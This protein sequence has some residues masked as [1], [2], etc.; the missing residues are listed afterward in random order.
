MK[1][2]DVPILLATAAYSLLF[3][4]QSAGL[5]YFLFDILLIIL[6]LV[7]DTSL[8]RRMTFIAAAAGCIVSSFFVFWY[9]TTLPF[10]AN[11]ISLVAVAGF[12]MDPESSFII[13][14]LHSFFSMSCVVIFMA[15][16]MLSGI[17]SPTPAGG[18]SRAFHRIFLAIIPVFIFFIFFLIYRQ[19]NPIFDQLAS[20]INFDWLSVGWLFFTLSGFL[21]MYGFFRQRV[22][23]SI[24]QRDHD[25]SDDLAVITAEQDTI[26][27]ITSA[28]NLVYTGVLLLILLNGLLAVVNGL[29]VYYLGIAHRIPA[30]IT[31]AQFLHNGTNAL[32][33]S[34]I[35]AISVIL[36]YFRGYLN[37]YEGNRW[38]KLLAY[39]WIAQ[40]IILV[41]ST[42]YRNYSY[43]SSYGL[44]HKRIGVY[45]Y[46]AL[47]ITGLVTTFIKILAAKNN[48]FLFRKNAWIMYAMLIV[49]VP[50]DWE[51]VI[52]DFNINHFQADQKMEIDQRYMA[53]LSHTNLAQLF[54]YYVVEQK[55]LNAVVDSS[56]TYSE[57]GRRGS[58]AYNTEIQNMLW[59]SYLH[60]DE[61]Y[62]HHDWQSYCESKTR[63]LAAVKEMIAT[64]HLICP[65][66]LR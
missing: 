15:A 10:A 57:T 51:T 34:I 3:Y 38:I 46:L 28:G 25:T 32:I 45:V 20:R 42:S 62:S 37:F 18:R 24:Q 17:I 29:D 58:T 50:V 7:R 61:D 53:D 4:R 30:G 52:V 5:N 63:N 39:L 54:R 48:W 6:L 11:V 55:S 27:Q 40:N 43:I 16:D 1:R 19:S 66:S 35:L 49:A 33:L 56:N 44:T 13:A 36:F 2:N 23:A 60:L 14:W 65:V 31:Y 26:A 21:L 9:G 12:S 59:Y 47:C 41:L 64:H 22:A 8:L